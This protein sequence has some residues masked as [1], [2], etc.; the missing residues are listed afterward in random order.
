MAEC[1]VDGCYRRDIEGDRLCHAHYSLRRLGGLDGVG[2]VE[3]ARRREQYAQRLAGCPL[4]QWLG[5]R[6]QTFRS[7]GVNGGKAYSSCRC[8]C[9][10]QAA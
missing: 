4:E 2:A 10:D 6:R 5:R 3:A 1:G 9:H 8:D 7:Q